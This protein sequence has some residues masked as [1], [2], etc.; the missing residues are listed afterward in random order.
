MVSSDVED[1][2]V[3]AKA[4]PG[5][6]E[7][8]P[9][10]GEFFTGVAEKGDDPAIAKFF[11]SFRLENDGL[12]VQLSCRGVDTDIY[13]KIADPLQPWACVERAL[14]EGHYTR[15]KRDKRKDSLPY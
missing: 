15:R 8:Y 6:I 12:T 1:P 2:R 13:V 9:T 14:T 3:L 11:L 10:L 7:L 5:L 4:I